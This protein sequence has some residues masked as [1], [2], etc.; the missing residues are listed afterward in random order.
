MAKEHEVKIIVNTREKE[1]EEKTISY[2]Q[3][4]VLAFGSYSTEE[5][6]VYT[7]DYSKGPKENPEGSLVKGQSVEVKEGMI[8]NV[9]HTNRS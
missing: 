7:V 3:V 5:K 2:E 1:W 6:A 4:V 8:F 9:K